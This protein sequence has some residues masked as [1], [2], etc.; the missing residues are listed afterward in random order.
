MSSNEETIKRYC[1]QIRKP[2]SIAEVAD[3]TNLSRP[4]VHWVFQKMLEDG[5]IERVCASNRPKLY[6]WIPLGK[7]PRPR[8]PDKKKE[9]RKRTTFDEMPV[10]D[11]R[12]KYGTQYENSV[13]S[14]SEEEYKTLIG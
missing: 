11:L 6:R 14:M 1:I 5:E 4:S 3:N 7:A 8:T 9:R 2:F 10:E 13:L 12:I